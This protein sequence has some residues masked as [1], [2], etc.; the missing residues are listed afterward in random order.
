[1]RKQQGCCV[2]FDAIVF[3]LLLNDFYR[4]FKMLDIGSGCGHK[5]HW[6]STI[7]NV[8]VGYNVARMSAPFS[9]LPLCTGLEHAYATFKMNSLLRFYD[10]ISSRCL[11]LRFYQSK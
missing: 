4:P 11:E 5:M 9:L 6:M 8:E 1:M 2:L 10:E 3:L 7:F